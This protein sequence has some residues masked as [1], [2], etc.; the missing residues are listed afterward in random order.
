MTLLFFLLS[1]S[2]SN[3]SEVE[4]TIKHNTKILKNQTSMSYTTYALKSDSFSKQGGILGWSNLLTLDEVKKQ[5]SNGIIESQL[6]FRQDRPNAYCEDFSFNIY[7]L[8]SNIKKKLTSNDIVIKHG[9]NKKVKTKEL[10]LE[11]EEDLAYLYL[12]ADCGSNNE[13]VIKNS[14]TKILNSYC[15]N[16]KSK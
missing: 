14:Y 8:E 10:N 16:K 4:A 6:N 5:V 13:E 11:I 9:Q 1:T 7:F 2:L 3:A 15:K 12:C